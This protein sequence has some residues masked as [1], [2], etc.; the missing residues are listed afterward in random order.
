MVTFIIVVY[1][2]GT[3]EIETILK[4]L[5]ENYKDAGVV[6]KVS[7]KIEFPLHATN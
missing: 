3:S 1:Y 2:R 4:T 6:K 7:G 5:P